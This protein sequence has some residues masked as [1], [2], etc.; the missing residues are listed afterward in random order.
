[1]RKL[2]NSCSL[3]LNVCM[4]PA[5]LKCSIVKILNLEKRVL[6]SGGCCVLAD[7]LCVDIRRD[8]ACTPAKNKLQVVATDIK[9]WDCRHSHW[10]AW[11]GQRARFQSDLR[12]ISSTFRIQSQRPHSQLPGLRTLWFTSPEWTRS[13][14]VPCVKSRPLSVRSPPGPCRSRADPKPKW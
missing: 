4:I 7:V 2:L 12:F 3:P 14:S 10:D 5:S 6:L 13:P 9:S 1:M 11:C 8:K